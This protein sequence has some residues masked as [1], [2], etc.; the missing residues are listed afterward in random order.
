MRTLVCISHTLPVVCGFKKRIAV[1]DAIIFGD[2]GEAKVFNFSLDEERSES[3]S[4]VCVFF[5][6]GGMVHA[7][8]FTALQHQRD[9]RVK[10]GISVARVVDV[11]W[12]LFTTR[13]VSKTNQ[14]EYF[15]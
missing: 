4:F 11:S 3:E 13:Q 2:F 9:E 14:Q 1:G 5:I 12:R 10:L 6:N 8:V 7:R 15:T